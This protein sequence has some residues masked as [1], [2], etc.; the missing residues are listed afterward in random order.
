MRKVISACLAFVL[1]FGAVIGYADENTKEIEQTDII[2]ENDGKVLENGVDY[3]LTYRDNVNVGT[4]TLVVNFIGNYSGMQERTF[5]IIK[6][7]VSGGGGGGLRTT[8]KPAITA[9]PKP[10]VE[11]TLTPTPDIKMEHTSYVV[12]DNGMFRPEGNMTR[13]EAATIFARLISEHNNEGIGEYS[14]K[15]KDVDSSGWY[16][17]NIAYL[18]RYDVISGYDE[19]IFKPQNSI[20]RAEFTAICTRFYEL[21]DDISVSGRNIFKDVN[22]DYW[23]A[24]YIFVGS[25]MD[26]VEGYN[27][28]T[29]RPN[30]N[31][32]RA[33][34][35]S[36][37]NRVLNRVPD[38]EYINDNLSVLNIFT[39]IHQT[40]W[41][42]DNIIEACT[43]HIV[44][45]TVDGESWIK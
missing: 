33:E 16:S 2:I 13:A 44:Q 24:T 8:P 38:E 27:D 41:A 36:I 25:D 43:N 5:N 12:G 32:T 22:E 4:A 29:F 35:V 7:Q 3:Y 42:F 26:W 18:E 45:K 39:D 28:G 20:T 40:H 14:S 6:K 21:F 23:A 37:I 10:T 9:T 31:I 15:F 19:G 34:V 17:R 11:P 30:D 1:C